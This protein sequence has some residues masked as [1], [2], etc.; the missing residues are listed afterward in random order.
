MT[1]WVDIV[2]ILLTLMDLFML[3]AIRLNTSIRLIALQ[4]LA[5][6]LMPLLIHG[7]ALDLLLFTMLTVAVKAVLM[8]AWLL[9]T[10]HRLDVNWKDVPYVGY[11]LS[12]LMG[13]LALGFALWVSSRLTLP[14]G[15]MA[16]STMIV[17]VAIFTLIV[18]LFLIISRKKALSQ[19]IGYVVLEN[20]I[21]T[22]GISFAIHQP[23]LI[24]L[25]ILLDVFVGVFV[26]CIAMFHISRQFDHIDT[27]QLS[28]LRN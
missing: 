10:L 2:L 20:G 28:S 1:L 16:S 18:G 27:D 3:G 6:G 26:M 4:G 19:V 24:E 13:P 14:A 22:F 21:Y 8:P 9:R 17:P 15:V 25:G 23:L 11:G 7:F 5:L 12:I